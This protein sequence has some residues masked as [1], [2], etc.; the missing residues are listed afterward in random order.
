MRRL[1]TR[2]LAACLLGLGSAGGREDPA[3]DRREAWRLTPFVSWYWTEFL[4]S[5]L[6]YQHRGGDRPEED[7]VYLQITWFLGGHPPHPYWEAV[8]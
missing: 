6:S 5:R 4:C 3:D 8:H 2:V 7:A 1:A